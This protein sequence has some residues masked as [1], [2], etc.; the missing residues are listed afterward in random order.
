[1][2]NGDWKV[3][4]DMK[5]TAKKKKKTA[6]ESHESNYIKAQSYFFVL[7]ENIWHKS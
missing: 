2:S 3:L 4:G 6:A 1:M 5:P 7:R